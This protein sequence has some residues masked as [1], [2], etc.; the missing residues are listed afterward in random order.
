[1]RFT[2][3][4]AAKDLRRRLTDPAALLMWVGLPVILGG[5]MSMIG[6][7]TTVPKAHLL[8]VDEDQTLVSGLVARAGNSSQL[9]QFLQ[10]DP[11][12]AEVGRQRIDAG[13]ASALL[14]IPKGFQDGVL[15]EQPA[16]LRLVTNPAQRIL[17]RIIEEG[18]RIV[19]EAVFYAQQLFREPLQQVVG[20]VTGATGAP[21]DD[22]VATVSRAI[23]QRLRMLE[24]TLLP[25][26]IALEV[27]GETAAAEASQPSFGALFLPGL[28]FMALLFTAQGMSVDIWTEKLGGTLRRTIMAPQPAAAFLGGKMLAGVGIMSLAAAMAIAVGVALFDVPV[29]RAPLAL[30]WAAY[31]GAALLCYL[32]LIDMA[33][34]SARGAQLLGT[35]MVFP[36][37]MIGGSF[38]PF[39][40]MPP[41]MAGIGR[42][43]PNGLA[44]VQVKALLFGDVD[45]RSL[46]VSALGIG[47]PAVLAFAFCVRRL[48]GKFAT[49]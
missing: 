46:L 32:M 3:I 27:K 38:F 19:I 45:V 34:T 36:L 13:E 9:S 29:V 22:A 17:P 23:N 31:A 41:W 49:S 15:R 24:K 33:A 14:V 26:L 48:T 11:V 40:A 1:V 28:L 2:L 5:L 21:T 6:D 47:L 35:L 16:E 7:G 25:P 4:A 18:L 44:V 39:E 10:I 30:V 8:L 42:W 12:S 37:I 43:T 20:S